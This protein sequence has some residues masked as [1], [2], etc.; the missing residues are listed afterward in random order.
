MYIDISTY[1]YRYIY[2]CCFAQAWWLTPVLGSI[3]GALLCSSHPRTLTIMGWDWASSGVVYCD[4]MLSQVGGQGVWSYTGVHS[5]SCMRQ[6]K[7]CP[8]S[9]TEAK[10]VGAFRANGETE[11]YFCAACGNA[12]GTV[13][14][15]A[16]GGLVEACVV[17]SGTARW[18][19]GMSPVLPVVVPLRRA[20]GLG[21]A[22][23]GPA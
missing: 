10:R 23:P 21:C 4:G 17:G 7:T 15:V 9:V 13:H 16:S 22:L 5:V 2:L 8:S 11:K 14:A 19:R 18:Q 20:V 1:V 3:L 6:T 12:N